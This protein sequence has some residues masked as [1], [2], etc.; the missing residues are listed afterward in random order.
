[1]I[2]PVANVATNAT[3]VADVKNTAP[4]APN[5]TGMFI[6]VFS[7]FSTTIR[8]TL[9]DFIKSFNALIT[10]LPKSEAF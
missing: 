4:K 7:S 8:V 3:T 6:T 1:M 2:Q 9:P 10:S 5:V